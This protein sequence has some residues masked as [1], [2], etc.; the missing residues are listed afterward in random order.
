MREI[1]KQMKDCDNDDE[2]KAIILTGTN[3]VFSVGA[4]M[5]ELSKVKNIGEVCSLLFLTVSWLTQLPFMH[6]TA[7]LQ[8]LQSPR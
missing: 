1:L 8:P 2:I 6:R 4:D 5:L 7:H 3:G